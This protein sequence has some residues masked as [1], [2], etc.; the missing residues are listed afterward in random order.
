MHKLQPVVKKSKE[1]Y[2]AKGYKG[3]NSSNFQGLAPA[4]DDFNRH[5]VQHA[6]RVQLC[7]EGQRSELRKASQTKLFPRD[8]QSVLPI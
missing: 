4:L 7:K 3:C 8:D 6:F 1:V 2:L 5:D